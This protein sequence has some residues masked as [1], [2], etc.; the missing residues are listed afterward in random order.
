[1]AAYVIVD[2]EVTDA[3]PY[4]EYQ[5]RVSATIERYGG[6]YLVRGG[7]FE[8]LEGDWQPKRF[9]V[10]EFPSFEQAKAWYDSSEYREILPIRERH[11]RTS[12]LALADGV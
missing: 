6:R 3:E 2:L 12:F 4:R 11:A 9:V 7:R 8:T 10:L 1:M 5:R